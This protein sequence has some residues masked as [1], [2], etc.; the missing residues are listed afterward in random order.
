G[1]VSSPANPTASSISSW[2]TGWS[3]MMQAT[4]NPGPPHVRW[5]VATATSHYGSR[6]ELGLG[7]EIRAAWEM[8]PRSSCRDC[9]SQMP[10]GRTPYRVALAA[11]WKAFEVYTFKERRIQRDG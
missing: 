1:M 4:P 9:S 11:R 5:V 8:S 7:G 3:Q 6:N 10:G 2:A